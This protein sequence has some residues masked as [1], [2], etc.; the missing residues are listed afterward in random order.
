MVGL[1]KSSAPT[2]KLT[3]P[4]TLSKTRIPKLAPTHSNPKLKTPQLTPCTPQ[5]SSTLSHPQTLPLS[6][7]PT[8]KPSNPKLTSSPPSPPDYSQDIF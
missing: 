4:K 3:H 2:L 5:L 7:S 6:N 1:L 8:L